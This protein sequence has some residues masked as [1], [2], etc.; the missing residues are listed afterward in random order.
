MPEPAPPVEA[1]P[2]PPDDGRRIPPPED[3][4]RIPP[5]LVTA[6]MSATLFGAIAGLGVGALAHLLRSDRPDR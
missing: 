1:A 5:P 4:R 3:G 6:L 2:P